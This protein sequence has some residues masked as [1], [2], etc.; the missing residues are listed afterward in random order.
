MYR[1]VPEEGR[2]AQQP[3][4]FDNTNADYNKTVIKSNLEKKIIL[5]EDI[6]FCEN[7][8]ALIFQH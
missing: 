1:Q 2:R 6:R 8:C 3:K 5:L 4:H 7:C